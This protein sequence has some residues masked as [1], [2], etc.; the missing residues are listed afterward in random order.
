MD[1]DDVD[2]IHDAAVRQRYPARL[3]LL[4]PSFGPTTTQSPPAAGR[5]VRL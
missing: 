2:T 1:R 3:L 4:Q 5:A